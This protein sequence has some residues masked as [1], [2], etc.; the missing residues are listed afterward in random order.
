MTGPEPDH[1]DPERL[2]VA[3]ERRRANER[4]E[5]LGVTDVARVHHDER[6]VEPLL[7]RPG[8]AAWLWRELRR[9]D[10]VRDHL[11]ARG[12]G[13]LLLP[14]VASSCPRSRRRGRRGGDR[15]PTSRRSAATRT[16]C[17]SRLS[18]LRDLGEDVLADDEQRHVEASRDGER[19]VADDR[20]VGHA[21][22]EIGPLAAERSRGPCRRG[23]SRSSTARRCNC[24]RS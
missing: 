18:A 1:D 9:V 8:V 24:E 22:H 2:E 23:S 7:R 15:A 3:Q 5:V 17:S 12:V 6:V 21:E 4:V 14:A 19:D 13:T 16:G 20:R 11:D 10:P